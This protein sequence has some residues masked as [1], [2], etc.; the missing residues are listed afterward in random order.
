M[1]THD[2]ILDV[3]KLLSETYRQEITKARAR[4]YINALADIPSKVLVDAAYQHIKVSKWFPK[5]AELIAQVDSVTV[6]NNYD[7]NDTAIYWQ[8]MN[9]QNAF[10]AGEITEQQ[11]ESNRAYCWFKR[12]KAPPVDA[13]DYELPA[14]AIPI[15]K[16]IEMELE[17]RGK[18][19]AMQ[20]RHLA[21]V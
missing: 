7:G 9:L 12:H 6:S 1:A 10:F 2:E 15:D 13:G 11:L 17:A 18:D 14:D 20:N 4:A 3:L 5:P 8:A 19:D 21:D 16:L